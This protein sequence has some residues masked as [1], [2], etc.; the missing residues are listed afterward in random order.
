MTDRARRSDAADSFLPLSAAEYHVLLVLA[1]RDLYGYAIL[2]AMQ[3]DSGG[4]VSL[5][6]GSLYRV[7]AR[8]EGVGLVQD[9]ENPEGEGHP[10]PGRPRRYY[11]LTPLG[12]A[13]LREEVQRM[14][15]AVSLATARNLADEAGR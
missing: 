6:I 8:L 1:D 3:E 12:R 15:R 4:T 14:K 10:S 7:I 9:A 11:R 2:Q 13:V 5:D